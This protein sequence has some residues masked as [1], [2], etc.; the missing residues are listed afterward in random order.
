MAAG[1]ISAG[2]GCFGGPSLAFGA[3]LLVGAAAEGVADRADGGRGRRG[4]RPSRPGGL[5][6]RFGAA[7]FWGG[8]ARWVVGF[9]VDFGRGWGGRCLPIAHFR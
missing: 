4:C 6:P 5:V 8:R 9:A 3:P 7:K 2:V 1:A